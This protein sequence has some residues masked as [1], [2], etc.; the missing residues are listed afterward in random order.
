MISHL[1][2][3]SEGL[4]SE[5][6]LSRALKLISMV[7]CSTGSAS[8]LYFGKFQEDFRLRNI[9]VIGF[10]SDPENLSQ[11]EAGFLPY[12]LKKANHSQSILL[13]NHDLNYKSHFKS[14]VGIEDA[15]I[16][17]STILMPVLPDYFATISTRTVLEESEVNIEY[18][19]AIRALLILFLR[20]LDSS[21]SATVRSGRTKKESAPGVKLT[22]RQAL[23]L[24]LIERG[25]TNRSIAVKLGYSESLI[26]QE[27]MVIYKKLGIDGRRDLRIK[28][29]V[30]D[31]HG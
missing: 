21:K 31:K 27:T 16:W 30:S 14:A 13:V 11:Y 24:E 7:A 10:N 18:F 19:N 29:R 23:I 15:D 12:Y 1:R 22:E 8:R 2:R 17:Q 9:F 4:A 3:I 5:S 25:D 20:S 26:R 28:N 6:D